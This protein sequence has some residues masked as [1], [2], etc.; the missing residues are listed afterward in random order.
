MLALRRYI[1]LL[2]N[3]FKNEIIFSDNKYEFKVRKE[4]SKFYI[5]IA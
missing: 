4:K 2:Y 3:R 5:K 1:F